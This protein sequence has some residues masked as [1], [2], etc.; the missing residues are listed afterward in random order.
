MDHED[1]LHNHVI[2]DKIKANELLK[3]RYNSS[4]ETSINASIAAQR[5]NTN[6]NEANW[7]FIAQERLQMMEQL[8]DEMHNW[9]ETYE[10][11]R[12]RCE[13]LTKMLF[14]SSL[15]EVTVVGKEYDAPTEIKHT[16]NPVTAVRKG[17]FFKQRRNLERMYSAHDAGVNLK[18]K[19]NN[20]N[21]S[22]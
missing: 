2:F 21:A 8:R 13:L 9:Q 20:E 12:V 3:R 16:V 10:K 6:S 1:V 15:S 4:Q 22:S 17:N 18:E 5:N 11:E 7:K 19:E 14:E